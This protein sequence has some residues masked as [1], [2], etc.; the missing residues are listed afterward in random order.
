MCDNM[1]QTW[2]GEQGST[3]VGGEQG[4]Q[5][6]STECYRTLYSASSKSSKWAITLDVIWPVLFGDT[7]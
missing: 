2:E 1:R 7:G 5:I 3:R 4:Y 6:H